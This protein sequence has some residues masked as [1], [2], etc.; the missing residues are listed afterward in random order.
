MVK[1]IK[2]KKALTGIISAA[3]LVSS[4]PFAGTASVSADSAH[5]YGKAL[6]L[7]LYFYDANMCGSGITDGALTWRK[8]CHT[9]DSQ[10]TSSN[11]N[12]G[13][14][15][16][17]YQSSF[18]PD[19]DGYIDLSGGYHDAGDFIKFN[20]PAS[21]AASTLAWGI[22]EFEDAYKETGCLGHAHNILRN[23]A[24]YIVKSTFLDSNGKAVAFC[25]QV[26]D[27]HDHDV[28][29][30]PEVDTSSSMNRPA[31]FVTSSN[32]SSDQCYQAAAALAS[33]AVVLEETDPDAAA[34]YTKY[35]EILYNFG[36]E[37]GSSITYEACSQFYSSSTYKDDKAWSECWLYLATDNQTYLNSA[38]NCDEYDGWIHCWDKVMGGYY[39]MMYSITGESSWKSKIEENLNKLSTQNVTPQGYYAIGGGW[40]SA[41]YNTAWQM[42]A[43]TYQKYSGS[44]SWLTK[45]QRQMDYLLGDNNLGQ[46]YLI[47]YGDKYPVN[48]HHR[49]SGQNLSSD[50]D[51]SAQKYTLWGAL[52]GGPGGDDSYEDRTN[53]Y[54]K[55]EVAIDYN[56]ACVGALAGLYTYKG[57]TADAADAIVASASEINSDYDFGGSTVVTPDP[58][59]CSATIS[60]VDVDTGELV[61]G[62]DVVVQGAY[63]SNVPGTLIPA[64]ALIGGEWNTSDENPKTLTFTYN[65]ISEELF[66]EYYVYV[67]APAGYMRATDVEFAFNF[68][69]STNVEI[70]VELQKIEETT[71]TTTTT[72]TPPVDILYGD[73]NNNGTVEVADAVFIL[74]GIADPGNEMFVLSEEGNKAADVDRSGAADVQDAM[75]IQQFKADMLPNG[76]PV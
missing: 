18:D 59:E 73:A 16:S 10:I 25:Y 64:L 38:K 7:S 22:Y 47:G 4:V 24:D 43:A 70:T 3:M 14:L 42:Y 56:A 61:P 48:P 37:C 31:Y 23:F 33:I 26:G 51:T 30:A 19:G 69:E 5:D 39:C 11:T 6:E 28:W 32:K 74:Q 66:E 29:R 13:S 12:L 52:V 2:L 55:N 36:V 58:I 44:D 76:L 57:G 54:V 72:T 49:G 9:Y 15:Y 50:S 71:T 20:L 62:A 63:A 1:H 67:T 60:V 45:Y 8:D 40:G 41:R 27:A 53:D 46:S 35:A 34:E 65:S 68:L 75:I 17:Q 21:Y